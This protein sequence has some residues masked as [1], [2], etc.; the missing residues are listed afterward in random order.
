MFNGDRKQ[1]SLYLIYLVI[2]SKC[3]TQGL[4][5][6][7]TQLFPMIPW[8]EYLEEAEF[9]ELHKIVCNLNTLDLE[10]EIL[11]R[12]ENVNKLDIYSNTPLY[13]AS[14]L[15]NIA[16]VRTLLKHGADPNA[17][18]ISVLIA[19]IELRDF[20]MV[21]CL[22]ESGAWIPASVDE[23]QMKNKGYQQYFDGLVEFWW[24]RYCDEPEDECVNKVIA[25]DELLFAH[26][27]D[28]N[29]QNVHGDSFLMS[30]A[31]D[32]HTNTRTASRMRLVLEHHADTELVNREGFRALHHSVDF[33]NA[34]A[35]EKLVAY[36]AQLDAKTGNGSTILHLAVLSA[37]E[38]RLI[39]A[40]LETDLSSIDL[41]ARDDSGWTAFALLRMRA[42]KRRDRYGLF[43]D[44]VKKGKPHFY[45]LVTQ[46]MER[47]IVERLD[48]LLRRI[49]ETRGVPIEQR[50]PPLVTAAGF[51]EDSESEEDEFDVP[52][53]T[54]P[55]TWPDES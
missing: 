18:N 41:E 22:F 8:E 37:F 47:D 13:Y 48:T 43:P 35:F 28:L 17:S 5:K 51:V 49:Q 9:T 21:E 24:D 53:R 40:M 45:F 27:F 52:T 15:G 2:T 55:G 29:Y 23:G 31:A 4:S 3:S 36:G 20:E 14:K 38:S 54:L 16:R 6:P 26:K 44:V 1:I 19:P 12:P 50:Y 33:S 39:Q 46:E 7:W 11:A 34:P 32:R 25:F 10:K 42:G 30:L